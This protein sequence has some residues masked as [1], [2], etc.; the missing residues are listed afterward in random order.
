MNIKRFIADNNQ[1]ALRMIKKEMGPDAVILRTRAVTAQDASGNNR[2][3]IE[4][5]AAI[6]YEAPVAAT[7][8]SHEKT[9]GAQT[10]ALMEKWHS[11]EAEL[12]DIKAA[13]MSA[14]MGRS[15]VPEL[16]FNHSVRALYA[17]LQAFG[18]Q[19]SI[20]G[21]IMNQANREAK[22]GLDDGRQGSLKSS[23]YRVL[24]RIDTNPVR[25]G[26]GDRRIYSFLGPTGVGKTTTL[27]KLAALNAVKQGI[28]TVLITLDT[29]R[30]AAVNQLQTYARIMG[31]PLEVASGR[32][33]LNDA[34]ERHRDC[35]LVLIDTA[36]RSPNCEE[37]INELS[38]FFKGRDDI[39]PFLVLSAATDYSSLL[40][41]AEQ[42]IRLSYKS[43]I[44]TKLDEVREISTMVNFLVAQNTPVSFFTTG[45]QVPEDIEPAT[46]KRIAKLIL[47]ALKNQ[48]GF[49]R[50]GDEVVENGSGNGPQILG[51][52]S[53]GRG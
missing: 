2:R 43:F 4:V 40:R 35:E 42:F 32:H 10:D 1:E 7:E 41:A 21:E 11:L 51:R 29:F 47:G 24:N 3:R 46:K 15:L 48:T 12:R 38:I 8:L 22:D 23:L 44:F 49:N 9:P 17:H 53:Y 27:A 52:G 16:Y 13:I 36:G 5:T 37:A 31:V 28:S 39:H 33:E 19:P 6:D 20:I 25:F 50:N 26:A 18:L 45:Q 14:D 34:L 30:I